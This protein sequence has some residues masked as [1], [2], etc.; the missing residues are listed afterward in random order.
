ML[1]QRLP[2]YKLCAQQQFIDDTEVL[3]P[4]AI[5]DDL[6]QTE[7]YGRQVEIERLS[8][9]Y[10]IA[11]MQLKLIFARSALSAGITSPDMQQSQ[12]SGFSE[13]AYKKLYFAIQDD[14][15]EL[16]SLKY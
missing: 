2:P 13:K 5:I 9:Q 15:A 11:D 7:P 16:D 6:R 3:I 1:Y 12:V 4:P 8:K 10:A 14:L